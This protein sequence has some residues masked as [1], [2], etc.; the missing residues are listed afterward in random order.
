ME[1]PKAIKS[2]V[3]HDLRGKWSYK[4]KTLQS[5]HYIRVGSRMSLFI[6]TESDMDGN[7]S[8]EI[9]LRDSAIRGIP[10]LADAIRVTEEVIEE[11]EDFISQYTMLTE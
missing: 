3:L 5:A 8:Y 4:G 7:L 2:F 9:Q 11:N 10:T 6:N 1:F